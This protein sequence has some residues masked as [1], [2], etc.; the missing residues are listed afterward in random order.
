MHDIRAIRQ[1]P[2]AF[3]HD[4]ARRGLPARADAILALDTERRAALTTMQDGQAQRNALSKQIG[5][6]KRTGGKTA[7][8]EDR[9]Y[10][11][12]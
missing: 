5:N 10:R 1:D 9:G 11:P 8:L 2:A 6:F 12:A 7:D 4:L 3:D